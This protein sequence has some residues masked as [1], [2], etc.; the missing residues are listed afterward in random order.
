[1]HFA[2]FSLPFEAV[3]IGGVTKAELLE[4]LA[5]AHVEI[6][7]AGRQLFADERFRTALH[8]QVVRVL[9][10]SVAGLGLE[11]G[12]VMS[13][14]LAAAAERGLSYCPMELAP[15]LRLLLP[16][17]DEGAVGFPHTE[18]R[19]PPGSITVLS[20]P[21]SDEE[22]VPKGFYLRRIEGRLWLR[23]YT[24]W[25]GHIWQPED[26]LVFARAESTA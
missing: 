1:M 2:Q 6:N 23:G 10:V 24:S 3:R 18:H 13:E 11:Q 26:L 5:A 21:L 19:A 9:Q 16:D 12:G 14:V 7:S 4:R 17:Q 22:H 15:H 25:A 8:P 20:P